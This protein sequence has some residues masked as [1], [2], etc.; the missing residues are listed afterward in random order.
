M[1]EME[2]AL[3]EIK[4]PPLGTRI[5]HWEVIP[6]T[7]PELVDFP[8]NLSPLLLE[9]LKKRG[10]EG[11]YTHQEEAYCKVMAGKDIV[12]VTP[13]ASG[14]TLCYTLPVIDMMLKEKGCRALYFFP[15][16]ALSHDQREGLKGFLGETISIKSYTYDGDTPA[17]ARKKIRSAGQIVI[18]NPDMLHTGILPHHTKWIHLFENLKFVVIDELHYYRGILGSHVANVLRRLKRICDFYGTEPIFITSSATVANPLQHARLLLGREEIHLIEKSGAPRGKK[19]FLFYNPPVVDH[20]LGIRRSSILEARTLAK[21]FIKKK[22]QTIVFSR[23]RVRTEVLT[24][25]LKEALEKME[26]RG[27]IKGYRGGYLPKERR[28]IEDGLRKGEIRGVV[29]TNA[30]ELGIDIGQLQSAI[31]CGYPGSIASTWQQAGRG[32]RGEEV[33]VAILIASSSP[34]DQ[35]IIKNPQYFFQKGAEYALIN[36][37]NLVILLSHLKCAAFE[38]PFLE[39][40]IFGLEARDDILQFLVEER[41]LRFVGGRYYW[42]A[43]D[44]PAHN[45]SL[46]CASPDNF[47]II[48][49]TEKTRVIGEVDRFSAHTLIHE[50]AIYIHQSQQYHITSLDYEKQKAYARKVQ[51]NYYTD[52]SLAVDI[53]VLDSFEEEE[54]RGTK[55]EWGEVMVFSRATLFKKIKFHT[56]ENIG[57][58]EINLPE[59]EMHTTSYW[60][61]ITSE[62]VHIKEEMLQSGLLGLSNLLVN[63]APLQLMCDPRD[64]RVVTQVRSPFTKR[65]T[66]FLYDHYPGGASFSEKLYLLHRDLL[67]MAKDLVRGCSCKSGCPSCVGPIE[68]V[69][70]KGKKS[71]LLLLDLALDRDDR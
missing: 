29:S 26:T 34:M 62:L 15:T 21:K 70:I 35:F 18:T 30:L 60:F 4:T 7:P 47:V 43:D 58:G 28:E 31:I 13:T 42:M 61:S 37:E 67:S 45:V 57:Y 40:E 22:I 56:H 5:T 27:L 16:K 8:E 25:Y 44:Y 66:I 12:V 39:R 9:A 6:A 59:E 2:Q 41:I 10:I 1:R 69:G 36:P 51:V 48:D 65:P 20:E 54:E 68:E 38:L 55:K 24:S 64:I 32:G 14:K 17:R 23:S 11:L 19:H 3:E 49:E 46:R 53:K 50:D 33:S 71:A 52:A 63:L